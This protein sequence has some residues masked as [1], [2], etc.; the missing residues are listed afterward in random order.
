INLNGNPYQLEEPAYDAVRAYLQH[1][2]ASL[3]ANPDKAEVVRDL[4]QAIA[5]KCASYLSPAK[6]VISAAEMT[7]ILEEMGP[8]QG[9]HT[10]TDA[11]GASGFAGGQSQQRRLYRIT[12]G[13]QIAG[14]C[15][16]M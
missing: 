2:E 4:E 3:E 13:A 7:K 15:A 16:G 9:E 5:D 14:V 12:E 10:D 11:N 6:T 8:V 1:A